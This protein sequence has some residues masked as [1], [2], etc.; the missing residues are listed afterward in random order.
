MTQR[1]PISSLILLTLVMCA[2]CPVAAAEGLSRGH[3]I[4]IKR[5]LQLQA[6]TFIP[7]TGYFDPARW[8]ESNFTAIDFCGSVYPAALMPTGTENMLWSRY[9]YYATDTGMVLG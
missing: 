7:Q 4:L 1:P 6:M 8:A 2:A 5:G 9:M 3:E